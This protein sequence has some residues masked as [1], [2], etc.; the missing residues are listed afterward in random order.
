MLSVWYC[1]RDQMESSRF[2]L[3]AID[4]APIFPFPKPIS[5]GR[6]PESIS[7][8]Q[9]YASYTYMSLHCMAIHVITQDPS[10]GLE[11][12]VII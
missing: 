7:C 6:N 8:S 2:Q 11:V 12:I 3:K 10:S 1:G 5:G 9:K 4:I